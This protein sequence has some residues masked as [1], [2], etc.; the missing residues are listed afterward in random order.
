MT[1][2]ILDI[3][4]PKKGIVTSGELL[5]SLGKILPE[6][7]NY[8]M[9]FL[10]LA[11]FWIIHI[12]QIRMIKNTDRI[13]LILNFFFLFFITIF[14][15]STSLLGDFPDLYASEAIFHF[16]VFAAYFFAYI[17]W[18]Y[19]ISKKDFLKEDVTKEEIKLETKKNRILLIIPLIITIIG[20]LTPILSSVLFLSVPFVLLYL[21]KKGKKQNV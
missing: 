2:L 12:H 3:E 5:L 6:I 16:N 1:L 19:A 9:T 7:I 11:V 4:L 8:S 17:Q 14:P 18:H 20:L 15:F 21:N 13:H 10:L